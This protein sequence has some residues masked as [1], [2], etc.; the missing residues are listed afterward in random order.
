MSS[1]KLPVPRPLGASPGPYPDS[2]QWADG[3][4]HNRLPSSLIE[5]GSRASLARDFARK[6]RVGR[7]AKPIPLD[8][9]DLSA[10]ADLAATWLGHSTV[11]IEVDGLRILADPVWSERCSPSR[12]VG[13]KRFHPVPLELSTL[14]AIDAVLISHDHYD[15]LDMLTVDWLT[16]HRDPVFVVPLGIGA[17]LRRWGV[18]G[19]RIVELD[20]D[21]EHRIGEVGL[22]CTE[23]RH[24]S[25]RSLIN[26]TT[27]WASWVI[28][29]PSQ[30]VFFGGDTGFT[31][32]FE[33]IGARHGPFDLLVLPIGAYDHRWPDVHL[34]PD[35]ALRAR[36]ELGGGVLLP[37]HWAT[38]DLAFHPWAE[39][40]ERLLDASGG[41][42]LLTPRPGERWVPGT[43]NPVST[44]WR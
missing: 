35:E 28:T 29:G 32:A 1:R 21:D 30:R 18:S 22:T 15:H 14:P 36:A 20:W 38:F 19:N 10:A 23:A 16:R 5:G 31:P 40:I 4:F 13:P 27:L 24:F 42:Q 33:S 7:P 9:P 2:P 39:P 8:F 26:D 6:G 43:P 34:D 41:E 12:L 11:L 44:W 37:V 25:G 3:H 17:H